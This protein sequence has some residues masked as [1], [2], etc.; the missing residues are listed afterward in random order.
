MAQEL[1]LDV[2]AKAAFDADPDAFLASRG[3]DGL[4]PADVSD[5]VDLV[6]DTLPAEAAVQLT[7]TDGDASGLARLATFEPAV[8]ESDALRP[9]GLEGR[10]EPDFVEHDP[11]GELDL[12]LDDDDD[13]PDEP[14]ADDAADGEEPGDEPGDEGDTETEVSRAARSV[15]SEPDPGFGVGYTAEDADD[16]SPAAP[17]FAHL[18]EHPLDLTLDATHVADLALDEADPIAE[19][20]TYAEQDATGADHGLD[21]DPGHH[22]GHDPVHEG[23]DHHAPDQHA[24]HD[25]HLDLG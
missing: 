20:F 10:V 9:D 1:M 18:M 15:E 4:S 19:A 24:D 7:D 2:E 17:E 8:V 3:F 5:A 25:G 6:A 21:H 22:A 16:A 11:S 23:D 14:L 13:G 12:R